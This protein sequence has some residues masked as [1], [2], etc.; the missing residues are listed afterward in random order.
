M[1][2]SEDKF[3][4][5]PSYPTYPPYHKGEYLEDHFYTKFTKHNP[6]IDRDYIAI[7]WT[8]LYCE[9][10][11]EGLQEFLNTL[12]VGGR[13]F[14][15]CQHDDAPRNILPPDTVVFS[16]SQS[17][18]RKDFIPIPAI[19]S[20]IVG[21]FPSFGLPSIFASF[22]GS[23]THDIRRQMY[24]AI[25][26]NPKYFI[27]M[28]AWSPEVSEEK[29]LSH[30]SI[31]SCSKF[32]L[33]PRGYGN[34]SFRMYEAMQLGSVPVYISDDFCL[35]WSDELDWGEFAILVDSK[36]IDQIDNILSNVPERTHKRMTGYAANI[37]QR[38][39]TLDGVYDNII[40][41]LQ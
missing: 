26:S 35:P 21:N 2:Y 31:T 9:N 16:A 18:P 6:S 20:P 17:R 41:R 11:E 23:M 28:S 10:K 22:V 33:C 19:C 3:R 37:Y 29:L 36:Q 13:Y 32:T 25:G 7:S 5:K 27:G 34:T 40:K 38:F 15:I 30:L 1:I 24:L 39:F 14:T 4:P 12:P 8:T